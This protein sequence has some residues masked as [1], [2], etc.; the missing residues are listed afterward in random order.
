[1][2]NKVVKLTLA[3][4]KQVEKKTSILNKLIMWFTKSKY[5]HVELIVND[6]WISSSYTR[7][8]FSARPLKPINE[9]TD[10]KYDYYHFEPFTMSI[11][12]FHTVMSFVDSQEGSK[13]DV[14][15]ILFA[16]LFPLRFDSRNKWFCSEVCTK[17]LQLFLIPE[18]IDKQ[19]SSMSPGDLSRL[20]GM[21][22]K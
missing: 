22:K 15:G 18:V 17:L 16:Q 2:E 10:T 19:P 21:E 8:G 1:M 3:F 4:R 12:Q 20:F 13:Y 9:Q 5:Y 7:G 6:T 11:K 14:Q